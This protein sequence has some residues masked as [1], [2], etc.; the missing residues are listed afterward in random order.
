MID[1]FPVSVTLLAHGLAGRADLP[2]PDWLFGW[3][4]AIVLAASFFL[5]A[6]AWQ[7]PVLETS[8]ARPLFKLP[9]P[10]QPLC[11]L[12]GVLLTVGLVYAGFA[13]SQAAADNILPTFVYVF[14]WSLLPL[15]CAAFGDIYRVF[16]PWRAIGTAAGRLSRR[17]GAGKSGPPLVYP[18]RLGRW[19]A[20]L[21]LMTF[22]Y[23]ELILPSGRDPSVLASLTV[24]Y[25]FLQLSGMA[26]FGGERWL[27]RGDAFGC[28]FNFFSRISPLTVTHGRLAARTP[29]SGLTDINM[30]PATVTFFCASLGITAFDGAQEGEIWWSVADPITRF[31]G[32][33]GVG[34]AAAGRLAATFGLLA[35]VALIAGFYRLGVAGMR[36]SHI[37]LPPRRLARIFAP[38]LVPV[39][40]G[41]VLAHYFSFIM[42][43]GQAL[44]SLASDPL[45][46]G[47]D[48]FGTAGAGID[49][50]WLSSATIWYFQAGVLVLGHAAGLAVA[51]DKALAVWGRTQAAARSQLW[52]LV[53]MVGFTNLGL[54]LLSQANQ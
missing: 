3:A 46:D 20:L 13:G 5:F 14:L 41:Y 35:A 29:L 52:M 28:Y 7:R 26:L 30:L 25:G 37:E 32:D 17:L 15:I 12:A 53:V 42:F 38:S 48:W 4:A 18:E 11:G 43:Q 8:R 45:G 40:L 50:G 31:L 23:I 47:S 39:M 22:G 24:A 21:L 27:E 33:L 6:L 10:L 34:A 2:I 1:G 36:S 44:W 16:N 49:Y 9:R 19:P 51:H 54:W